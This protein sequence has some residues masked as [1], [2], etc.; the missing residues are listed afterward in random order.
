MLY[1]FKGGVTMQ[2]VCIVGIIAV[3]VV[4]LLAMIYFDRK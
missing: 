2:N 3:V 4:I 1:L